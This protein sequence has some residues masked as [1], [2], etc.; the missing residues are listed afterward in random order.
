MIDRVRELENN[1]NISR[2]PGLSRFKME[3]KSCIRLSRV[4]MERK[5]YN[6]LGRCKHRVKAVE[7]LQ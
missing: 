1:N 5:S 2:G 7:I 6:R 4:R 3:R